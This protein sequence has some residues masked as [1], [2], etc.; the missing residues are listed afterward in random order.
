MPF[1]QCEL[2]ILSSWGFSGHAELEWLFAGQ[3]R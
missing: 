3:D 1:T 2:L